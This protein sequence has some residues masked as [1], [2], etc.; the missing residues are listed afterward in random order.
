MDNMQVRGCAGNQ[1][2]GFQQ[3]VNE[4][5][6]LRQLLDI[7]SVKERLLK[8][9]TEKD[10]PEHRGSFFHV[11]ILTY[12]SVFFCILEGRLPQLEILIKYGGQLFLHIR[13]IQ[14]YL[15]QQMVVVEIEAS[16][17]GIVAVIEHLYKAVHGIFH[18]IYILVDKLRK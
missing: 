9:D 4:M 11:Q 18:P 12:F 16:T 3:R 6:S 5:E 7:Q 10:L 2:S 14:P 15:H 17:V 8:G 13:I 1:A